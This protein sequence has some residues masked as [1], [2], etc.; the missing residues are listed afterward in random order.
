MRVCTFLI[1]NFL[2]QFFHPAFRGH[3]PNGMEVEQITSLVS[4]FSFGQQLF[5]SGCLDRSAVTPPQVFTS[6]INHDDDG[7]NKKVSSSSK[8]PDDDSDSDSDTSSDSGHSSDDQNNS[9]EKTED[10]SEDITHESLKKSDLRCSA[11]K[12]SEK[13]LDSPATVPTA[14]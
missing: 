7:Q 5:N 1:L 12:L 9:D 8:D 14:V 13:L 6:P 3:N 4:I 10:T 2:F 11:A